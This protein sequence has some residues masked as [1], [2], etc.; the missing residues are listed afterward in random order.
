[1]LIDKADQNLNAARF[2]EMTRSSTPCSET[3]TGDV[4]VRRSKWLYIFHDLSTSKKTGNAN[5]SVCVW[6]GRVSCRAGPGRVGQDGRTWRVQRSM[7]GLIT[8]PLNHTPPD[9][10]TQDSAPPQATDS[11]TVA[12]S[13]F[14]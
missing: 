2:A 8:F 4:D 7:R 10:T 11:S 13:P 9:V 6:L 12:A 3:P 5:S 1:M 14:H